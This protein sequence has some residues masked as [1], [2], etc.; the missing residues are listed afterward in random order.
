MSRA[1][2]IRSSILPASPAVAQY[3]RAMAANCSFT[4]QQMS[5]P[6]PGSAD[7]THAAEYPVKVPTS[8]PF[9]AP[10]SWTS[11]ASSGP[12]SGAICHSA[13]GSLRGFLP[14]FAERLR[15]PQPD[16]QH[17]FV[18]PVGHRRRPDEAVAW[19]LSRGELHRSAQ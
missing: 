11:S 19:W 3:L 9:F 15:L 5:L 7:A 12:C 14:Q 6:S 2:P 18:Q 16:R 17:V 10:M 8:R 1:G 4:S 13:S